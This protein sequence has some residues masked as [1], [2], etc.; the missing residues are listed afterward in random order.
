MHIVQREVFGPEREVLAATQLERDLTQAT[1]VQLGRAQEQLNEVQTGATD[2]SELS[3]AIA[4]AQS[5]LGDLQSRGG[6]VDKDALGL[7]DEGLAELSA[8]YRQK[9]TDVDTATESQITAAMAAGRD[10]L[11]SDESLEDGQ[12]LLAK[13]DLDGSEYGPAEVAEAVIAR[14]QPTRQAHKVACEDARSAMVAAVGTARI[15]VQALMDGTVEVRGVLRRMLDASGVIAGMPHERDL[16]AA[17]AEFSNAVTEARYGT[18]DP[19]VVL[20]AANGLR[21]TLDGAGTAVQLVTEAQ[22]E[23]SKRVGELLDGFPRQA[24][25][26]PEEPEVSPPAAE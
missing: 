17:I 25:A 13:G 10:L 9:R 15:E 22:D 18:F 4:R 5:W 7:F 24:Q 14:N 21:Q 20:A 23:V 11:T 8:A 2:L 26:A 12:R 1:A 16:E 19:S 3:G 6:S